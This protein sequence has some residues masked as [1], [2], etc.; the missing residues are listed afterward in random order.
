[1][2][3]ALQCAYLSLQ[4]LQHDLYAGAKPLAVVLEVLVTLGEVG[5]P[6]P[7]AGLLGTQP[8]SDSNIQRCPRGLKSCLV[9]LLKI[10]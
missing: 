4:L 10:F 6:V 3:C 2:S 1:M 9:R 5:G 7:Q 8:K